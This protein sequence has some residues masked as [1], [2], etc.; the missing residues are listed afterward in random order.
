MKKIIW[1]LFLLN[2]VI[3]ANAQRDFIKPTGKDG[4]FGEVDS[5]S[6]NFVILK[7]EPHS[8]Y[9][10]NDLDYIE[11][12]QQGFK[13]FNYNPKEHDINNDTLRLISKSNP[14]LLLRKGSKV[15]IPISSNTLDN[16]LGRIEMREAIKNYNIW[17]VVPTP[18]EA[19]F[20]LNYFYDDRGSDKV[21]LTITSREGQLIISSP[22]YRAETTL[23]PWKQ[24]QESVSKL[25]RKTM[26]LIIDK[27][28]NK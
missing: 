24:A 4:F 5:L 2:L 15:F 14:E 22:K 17:T 25:L 28:V 18:F 6:S 11:F 21:Y 7:G 13:F 8:K 27:Y 26:P 19:E 3:S 1:T 23:S 12:E 16:V 10:T 20:I 9:A